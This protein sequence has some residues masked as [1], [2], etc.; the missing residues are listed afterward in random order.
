METYIN[1][2]LKALN[3]NITRFFY[4][5]SSLKKNTITV[6]E[7]N[8]RKK[9]LLWLPTGIQ[10]FNCHFTPICQYGMIYFPICTLTNEFLWAKIIR[11]GLQ[12]IYCDGRDS[13]RLKSYRPR[14]GYRCVSAM[15]TGV[16]CIVSTKLKLHENRI[17]M[18]QKHIRNISNVYKDV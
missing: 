6:V 10:P 15:I 16:P 18:T 17:K 2:K 14:N 4:V 12:F 13:N 9:F 5:L 7:S 11:H 8:L 1:R 3:R